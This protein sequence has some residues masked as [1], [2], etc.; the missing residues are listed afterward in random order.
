MKLINTG[1]GRTGTTS[2]K[3][4][5]DEL[6]IAPTYHSTS[7]L[8]NS[9]DLEKWQAA[10]KGEEVNWVEIFA[11]YE[12]ADWPAALFFKQIINAHPDAK[13]MITVRDPEG[14]YDSIHGML[15]QFM[16][17][18]L[19]FRKF[20]QFKDFMQK[21][22]FEELFDGKFDDREAMIGFF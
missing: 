1:I 16:R 15:S 21:Y 7:L 5:L 8:K 3:A 6:G 12:V 9:S 10:T 14:W 13:V 18:N 22:A 4:A 19:P 11:G 2:L 17:L 20:K